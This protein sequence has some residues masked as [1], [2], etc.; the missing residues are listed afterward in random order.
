M[1][2]YLMISLH[3]SIFSK[4]LLLIIRF[5]LYTELSLNCTRKMCSIGGGLKVSNNFKNDV[6]NILLLNSIKST[7]SEK[8]DNI[9]ARHANRP[10][11]AVGLTST[12]N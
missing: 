12:C 1:I 10:L 6:V 2:F 7:L 9:I 3:A 8:I 11:H 5:V 4:W